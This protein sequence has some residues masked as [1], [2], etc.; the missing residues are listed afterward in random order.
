MKRK[1]SRTKSGSLRKQ[2]SCLKTSLMKQGFGGRKQRDLRCA[3]EFFSLLNEIVQFMR[4]LMNRHGL[5]IK[6]L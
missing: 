5:Q 1:F 2:V 6:T 4:N 3:Q